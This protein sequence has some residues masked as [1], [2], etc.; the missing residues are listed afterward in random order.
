M[1]V[2]WHTVQHGQFPGTFENKDSIL[3]VE[4]V[5]DLYYELCSSVEISVNQ[6]PKKYR[7]LVQCHCDYFSGISDD[8]ALSST[9]KILAL[10]A[11]KL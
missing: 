7:H 9:N 8:S 4:G 5:S 1:H 6:I 2:I 10:I 3:L 11:V